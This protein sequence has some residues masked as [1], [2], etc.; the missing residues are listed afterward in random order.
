MTKPCVICRAPTDI[1]FH[2]MHR[3]RT[4]AGPEVFICTRCH[5]KA[6]KKLPR[7]D[8]TRAQWNAIVRELKET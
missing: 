7:D 3:G 1:H 5:P 6:V 8:A 2:P 4:S